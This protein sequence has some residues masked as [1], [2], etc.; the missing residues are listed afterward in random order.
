[1]TGSWRPAQPPGL[2]ET[3]YTRILRDGMALSMTGDYSPFADVAEAALRGLT[4]DTISDAQV[5]AAD[6]GLRR[7]ARL[8]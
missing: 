3:W 8:P 2:L 1:M 4:H 7:A 6:G 5:A